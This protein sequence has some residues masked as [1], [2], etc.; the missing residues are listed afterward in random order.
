MPY[1]DINKQRECVREGVRKYAENN[2]NKIKEYKKKHYAYK[3][4]CRRFMN[5]LI[6][7]V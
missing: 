6:D 4:E 5:I 2:S 3:T 7:L 1:K